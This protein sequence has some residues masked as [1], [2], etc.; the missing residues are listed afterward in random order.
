[1]SSENPARKTAGRVF[2]NNE[3]DLVF[4]QYYGLEIYDLASK[5][6]SEK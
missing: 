6:I 3:K 4:A 1:M 2:N 5:F